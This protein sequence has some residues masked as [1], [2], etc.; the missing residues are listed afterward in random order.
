MAARKRLSAVE[1][2]ML[3]ITDRDSYRIYR[4]PQHGVFAKRNDVDDKTCGYK[5]GYVAD[6]EFYEDK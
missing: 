6:S 4:C 1:R 2:V 5:C 3:E